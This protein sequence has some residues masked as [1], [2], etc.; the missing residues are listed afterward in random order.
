M[1]GSSRTG[2]SGSATSG[3]SGPRSRRPIRR[4]CL[5]ARG[6]RDRRPLGHDPRGESGERPRRHRADDRPGGARDAREQ[7]RVDRRARVRTG[8]VGRA[9][10]RDR[11][12]ARAARGDAPRLVPSAGL[13]TVRTLAAAGVV[14]GSLPSRTVSFAVFIAGC[15][16]ATP[17]SS[18][19]RSRSSTT[20]SSLAEIVA[21]RCSG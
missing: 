14:Y 11:R 4:S 9:R 20:P 17:A 1:I 5:R 15:S 3:C 8:D 10:R 13:Y 16:S 18:G 21:S 7:Q 6:P 2:R 12:R 19:R